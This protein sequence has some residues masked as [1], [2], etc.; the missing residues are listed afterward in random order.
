MRRISHLRKK[1]KTESD[2]PDPGNFQLYSN[3]FILL[4]SQLNMDG[5]FIG[6]V[7]NILLFDARFISEHCR[8]GLCHL[9]LRLLFEDIIF[10]RQILKEWAKIVKELQNPRLPDIVGSVYG[11][12]SRPTLKSLGFMTNSSS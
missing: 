8:M 3:R 4:N 9:P 10:A 5:I 6:V 2:I 1:S 11:C 7:E 12:K